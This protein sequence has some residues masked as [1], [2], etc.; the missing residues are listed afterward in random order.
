MASPRV[1]P[2]RWMRCHARPQCRRC[3]ALAA[4]PH[5]QDPERRSGREHDLA[6]HLHERSVVLPARKVGEELGRNGNGAERLRVESQA[7]RASLHLAPPLSPPLVAVEALL[8][9]RHQGR[10]RFRGDAAEPCSRRFVV[11]PEQADVGLGG[12]PFE[13]DERIGVDGAA[14][15]VCPAIGVTVGDGAE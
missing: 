3:A 14:R 11:E 13:G 5:R 12:E 2:P 15:V 9:V 1:V 4:V 7:V 10:P 8:L 6:E